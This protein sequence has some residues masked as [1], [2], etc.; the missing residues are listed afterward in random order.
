V[1]RTADFNS[2]PRSSIVLQ[3]SSTGDVAV[4]QM[5]G[6]AITGGAVVGS[7]GV[8]YKVVATG[9]FNGDGKSDILLQ[10]SGTGD[11]AVWMLNATGT[12]IASGAVLGGAGTAWKAITAGDFNGDGRS[13]VVLQNS[14]TGDVAVWQLNN[15]GSAIA[16]GAVL[17]GSGTAWSV[18]GSG[19]FNGDWKSEI[20]LQNS[21]TGGVA[22]WQLNASGTAIASGV[23]LGGS[24]SSWVT[25]LN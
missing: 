20:I 4:W 2:G 7:P 13:E 14:S 6:M 22:L 18:V 8:A 15:S 25:P 12:A 16:S 21:S 19:D 9:D 11:V 23:L 24:G 1:I 10:N 3:N 17:G 5:N